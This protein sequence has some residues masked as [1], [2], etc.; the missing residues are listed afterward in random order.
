MKTA[1]DYLETVD[2]YIADQWSV[3][4]Y[5]LTEAL[6]ELRTIAEKA[7]PETIVL[8]PIKPERASRCPRCAG[9]VW[10]KYLYCPHCGQALNFVREGA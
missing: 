6:D 2:R 8:P 4:E 10:K 3:E 9:T 7:M 1:L 5:E